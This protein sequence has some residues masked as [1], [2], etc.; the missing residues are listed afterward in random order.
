MKLTQRVLTLIFVL[1]FVGAG[2]IAAAVAVPPPIEHAVGWL[3][4]SG[5][6]ID[7][8]VV[9]SSDNM[10]FLRRNYLGE[11]DFEGSY[12]ADFR[13]NFD[14]ENE[15]RKIV[16]YGNAFS[17]DPNGARF[18]QLN[19]HRDSNF[20]RENPYIY[21]TVDGVKRTYQIFAVSVVIVTDAQFPYNNP[22]LNDRDF[23]SVVGR[24]Q[25]KCMHQ[26]EGITINA[27]DRL[28]MLDAPDHST[29]VFTEYALVVMAKLINE[30][31][32]NTNHSSAGQPEGVALC[33]SEMLNHNI[34]P[35]TG[36]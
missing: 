9:Q 20:V 25:E 32:D 28:F 30:A 8:V 2:T 26:I 36:R 34:N 7:E 22:N 29:G 27:S 12:Y 11:P 21:L 17:M 5:T 16:I 24:I 3:T 23:L 13:V 1:L 6:Y 15:S 19:R 18:D 35:R 31:D 14:P 33:S 4:V 10:Y